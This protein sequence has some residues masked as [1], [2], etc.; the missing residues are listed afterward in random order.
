ME[1]EKLTRLWVVNRLPMLICLL[2]LFVT[3]LNAA[4][5]DSYLYRTIVKVGTGQGTVYATY[6]DAESSSNDGNNYD[7]TVRSYTNETSVTLNAT[8]AEG[9]RFVNWVKDADN[10]IVSST[11]TAPTTTL[12]YNTT[13]AS[14]TYHWGFL[15]IG[16]Y[17]E[18]TT[19][20]PFSFTA[21]FAE[22]GAVVAKVYD[23]QQ[24]YG[25][26]TI[27]EASFGSTDEITLVATTINGSEL[28]GW[29]FD[30]WE[31]DGVK[32]SENSEFKVTVP[33]SGKNI[34]IA[35]FIK[36]DHENYC[37]IKHKTTGNYL[38]LS[39]T[40]SY[41]MNED[42][43]TASFNGSFTLINDENSAISDPGCV[44]IL[45]GASDGKG[46]VKNATLISQ[47]KSAGNTG[48]N[49]ITKAINIKPVNE[50]T[51]S[52]S[53]IYSSGGTDYTIYFNDKNGTPVMTQNAEEWEIQ[54][55]SSAN[56][57]AY[58]FGAYPNPLLTKDGKYY[59]TLYTTF[60]Y[61]LKGENMKAYYI[62]EGSV[63][64]NSN[65]VRALEIT[66]KQIPDHYPVILECGSKDPKV[67]KILPLEFNTVTSPG[68]NYL[69]GNINVVDGAKTS[70]GNIYVLSI[71][72]KSG[73]GYYK[74]KS[75]TALTDNKA[76]AYLDTETQAA[77]KDLSFSFCSDNLEA[78]GINNI[79][80]NV[81]K[82]DNDVIYDLQG[83]RVVNP[84]NGVYIVKGKKLF[85]K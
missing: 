49:I 73:L 52:I 43:Y 62:G 9:Y 53:T 18:Y 25:S 46:G 26:A 64:E 68:I 14:S 37:F 61:E 74:L 80:Q 28:V 12:V 77:A 17:R 35:H 83:R 19:R 54:T 27:K 16:R 24:S 70:D 55:L 81:N 6:S 20:R 10:S 2:L 39:G 32:V 58:N 11:S 3:D 50:G 72:S 40:S 8:P 13:G 47:E 22:E 23:G 79:S 59:T 21:N 5:P 75:G 78:A 15:G 60:P 45:I 44:F 48:K 42:T 38:K 56:L 36:A 65:L 29:S 84:S 63:S 69:K 31:L 1:K 33:E 67:N 76:Y 82:T 66:S 41:T 4:S 57:D 51:Y 30:Y 34:Y 85:I 71:G 7:A